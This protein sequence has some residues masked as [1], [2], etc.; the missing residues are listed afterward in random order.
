[1]KNKFPIEVQLNPD[2]SLYEVVPVSFNFPII[3]HE[4]NM[5]VLIFHPDS[6][7]RF[8][9]WSIFNLDRL[10]KWADKWNHTLIYED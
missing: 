10:K 7:E 4:E 3:T 6:N 9:E 5:I 2:E 8:H 1:M